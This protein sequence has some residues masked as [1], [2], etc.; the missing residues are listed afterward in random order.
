MCEQRTSNQT[1]ESDREAEA[2]QATAS[3]VVGHGG[4]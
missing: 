1:S 2:W 3:G 4:S